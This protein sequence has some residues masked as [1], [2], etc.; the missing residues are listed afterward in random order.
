MLGR[1]MRPSKRFPLVLVGVSAIALALFGW[2][3]F[4]KKAASRTAS[5]SVTAIAVG[6]VERRDVPVSINALAQAQGWQTVVVRPQVNGP[7]LQVPVREGSD[8]AKGD[9]IA[10]IDPTPFRH[11]LMQ[12]EGALRRDQAQLD[13]ARLK[14]AR[15]RQLAEQHTIATLDVDTQAALVNE[16]EGTVTV[17]Q[18][19]MG[20]AQ[21]NLT[22]T[23]IVAPIPGR[24][25]VRLVDAGNL[26]S[27][28][29]TAGIVTI[30]QISP[31]AVT[32][33]VPQGEFQRLSLASDGFRKPLVTEAYGQESGELLDTGELVVVD[34]RVDPNTATVQVKARFANA[35]HRLWPG[36]LLNVRLTLQTLQN[37]LA[38]PT[39]AVNQ[40]PKGPFAYVIENDTAMVRPL[41]IDV[42]QDELTTVK[43]GV[44]PGDTV[45]VEGQGSLRA[46]AKVSVRRTPM[47]AADAV[48]ERPLTR[49]DAPNSRES[50]RSNA[51]AA[52]DRE[53]ARSEPAAAAGERKPPRT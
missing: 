42:R 45:V 9:L 37:A 25:G 33:T 21:V 44:Q 19:A 5:P 3:L 36:Q 35:Q 29:D 14:L 1:H 4:H 34:N 17:D 40:G 51:D 20:A 10:E 15:Y 7:L 22:R 23:R 53:S 28:T 13:L 6:K 2:T 39:I 47:S 50:A 52:S 16:L 11:M 27:T 32:F 46:G 8:V 49:S 48:D 38:L 30:N 41:V 26:V 31:I 18:G 12:A 24:V 43:S